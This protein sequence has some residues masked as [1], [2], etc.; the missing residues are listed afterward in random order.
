LLVGALKRYGVMAYSINELL[1]EIQ[2]W[3]D[4]R[5]TQEELGAF[6]EEK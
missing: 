5:P 4:K 1:D 2:R 6:W 3:I